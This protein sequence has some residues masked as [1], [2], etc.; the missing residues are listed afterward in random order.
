MDMIKEAIK[1]Y[2]FYS[3]HYLHTYLLIFPYKSF[4]F[5][6]LFLINPYIQVK[7]TYFLN[8]HSYSSY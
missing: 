1:T 5:L 4:L 6:S 8:Y 2:D 3:N 7:L